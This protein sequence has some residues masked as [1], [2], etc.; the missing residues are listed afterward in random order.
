M[1]RRLKLRLELVPKPL[2]GR[3]LR[4]ETEGIGLTN[5]ECFFS[6]AADYLCVRDEAMT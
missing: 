2:Y 4:S 3:N 5:E 6:E 1:A